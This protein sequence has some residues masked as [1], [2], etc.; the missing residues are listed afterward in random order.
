MTHEKGNI[1]N[2]MLIRS[3][4]IV[5]QELDGQALLV[6]ARTG[7][8]W[9][10]NAAAL[11][12]WK[13]CDGSRTVESLAKALAASTRR[14]LGECREELDRFAQALSGTG[15]LQPMGSHAATLPAPPMLFN[16]GTTLQANYQGKNLG[17][18]RRR[19]SPRGNSGPG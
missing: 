4:E 19:P 3:S 2:A 14:S 7:A 5:W 10:L 8:R 6:H 18:P 17:G 11:A 16:I 12:V 13:L 9:T 1:M 15:L